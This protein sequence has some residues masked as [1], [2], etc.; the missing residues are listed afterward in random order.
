MHGVGP[1]A[2]RFLQTYWG[3]LNMVARA[4]GY[5]RIPFKGYCSITQGNPM[6]P[7]IFNVVMEAVIC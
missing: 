4:G 5:F 3:G 6:S 2:I 1:R 7:I